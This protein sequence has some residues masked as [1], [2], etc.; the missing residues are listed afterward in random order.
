MNASIPWKAPAVIAVK[1][2]G[3][4][5]Y[6]PEIAGLTLNA[7][8]EYATNPGLPVTMK[9]CILVN[10]RGREVRIEG[11]RFFSEWL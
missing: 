9:I 3:Q 1:H 6:L 8:L 7:A 4:L 2:K 11:R 10:W 5:D